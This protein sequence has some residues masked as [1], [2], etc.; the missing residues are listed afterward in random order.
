MTHFQNARAAAAS[1]D[2][3]SSPT[4]RAGNQPGGGAQRELLRALNTRSLNTL[5]GSM[6]TQAIQTHVSQLAGVVVTAGRVGQF[7]DATKYNKYYDVPLEDDGV[8]VL[9]DVRKSV[10]GERVKAGDYIRVTGIPSVSVSPRDGAIKIKL[11]VTDAVL[12]DSPDEVQRKRREAL[13]LSDVKRLRRA[14]G[15]FPL[16]AR[17]RIAVV[18]GR[19]SK[20]LADFMDGL[21]DEAP[22]HEIVAIE[23]AIND[24]EELAAAVEGVQADVLVLVRGGGSNEDFAV[25]DTVRVLSALGSLACFRVVGLG[26]SDDTSLCDLVVDHSAVTPTAAGVFIRDQVAAVRSLAAAAEARGASNAREQARA[27]V[28]NSDAKQRQLIE[29]ERAQHAK[30]IAEINRRWRIRAFGVGVALAGLAYLLWSH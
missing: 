13:A 10:F 8:A 21:G 4:G 9:M 12:V 2:L 15:R 22:N 30:A 20:V 7:R 1:A 28:D 6:A 27:L 11:D 25:F 16:K 26:H 3:R 19:S 23:V 24:A 29:R 18:H 14:R 17:M 5:F